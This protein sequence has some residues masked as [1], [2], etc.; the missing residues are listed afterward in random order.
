M[1]TKVYVNAQSSEIHQLRKS[2]RLP[3]R[4]EHLFYHFIFFFRGTEKQ[5]T[6]SPSLKKLARTS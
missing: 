4:S 1:R 6:V 2:E 3:G 5:P